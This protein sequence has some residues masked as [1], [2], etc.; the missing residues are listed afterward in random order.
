MSVFFNSMAGFLKAPS[1]KMTPPKKDLLMEHRFASNPINSDQETFSDLIEK[2]SETSLEPIGSAKFLS[3]SEGSLQPESFSKDPV[4]SSET[5]ALV[6]LAKDTLLQ[7]PPSLLTESSPAA[8][9]PLVPSGD[10]FSPPPLPPAPLMRIDPPR[11][12][13]I[14]S[15]L[16]SNSPGD[17][18][19]PGP[20]PPPS[21]A[22]AE[23]FKPSNSSLR[24][25]LSNASDGGIVS[26]A[27]LIGL[28]ALALLYGGYYLYQKTAAWWRGSS[29]PAEEAP[30]ASSEPALDA[31]NSAPDFSLVK[32]VSWKRIAIIETARETK[33]FT[34]K[35]QKKVLRRE[36]KE[37]L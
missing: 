19:P 12:K 9:S 23:S 27:A 30:I 26:K 6:K 2:V 37:A 21:T 16:S 8:L 11:K 18:S 34:L 4:S 10:D 35:I 25:L 13:H 31:A 33:R 14:F 32:K 36:V 3:V 28:G 7:E 5:T 1:F 29:K 24:V 20:P 15:A 22:L 17:P